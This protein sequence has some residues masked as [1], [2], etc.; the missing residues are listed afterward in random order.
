[1]WPFDFREIK[2][3]FLFDVEL[4]TK[5]QEMKALVLQKGNLHKLDDETFNAVETK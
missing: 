1:M 4:H 2:D 3:S 5:P